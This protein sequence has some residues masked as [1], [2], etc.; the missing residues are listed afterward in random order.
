MLILTGQR[1]EE[2]VVVSVVILAVLA[3]FVRA[4]TAGGAVSGGAACL[5]GSPADG[6]VRR[7][8]HAAPEPCTDHADVPVSGRGG[9][10]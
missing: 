4:P 10:L 7:G 8:G 6:G 9:R 1:P 5:V 3:A 2:E